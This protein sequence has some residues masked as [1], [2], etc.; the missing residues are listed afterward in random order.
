MNATPA[1]PVAAPGA[2]TGIGAY[3]TQIL[4]DRD[5]FFGEVAEGEGLRNKLAH[6]LWTLVGLSGVYGAAAGA[7]ASPAQ[8]RA[9]SARYVWLVSPTQP[10]S[11]TW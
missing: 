7:Y 3:L 10:S 1:T 11:K 8:A 4:S 6:A 5:R 9:W 2:A